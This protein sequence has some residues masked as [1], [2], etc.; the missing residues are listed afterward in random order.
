MRRGEKIHFAARRSSP[1]ILLLYY[2]AEKSNE[3][4]KKKIFCQIMLI[5][6]K[7]VKVPPCFLSIL[8][9]VNTT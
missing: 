3:K 6:M 2:T 4:R 5:F 1:V 9:T 7:K 8:Y